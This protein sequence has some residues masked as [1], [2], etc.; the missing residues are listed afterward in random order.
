MLVFIWEARLPSA[1]RYSRAANW[2]FCR[3]RRER[4]EAG[5][6][7][8]RVEWGEEDDMVVALWMGEL[9]LVV[10]EGRG[11]GDGYRCGRL[12]VG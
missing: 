10:S 8:G 9:A 1:V 12:M 6:E 2:L 11:E 5:R 3:S 4:V 7:R